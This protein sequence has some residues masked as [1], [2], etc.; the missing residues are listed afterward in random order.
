MERMQVDASNS[1]VERSWP[2]KQLFGG[3]VGVHTHSG[4][5][6]VDPSPSD[7]DTLAKRELAYFPYYSEIRIKGSL[8]RG[9]SLGGD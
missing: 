7:D 2:E 5:Y 6:T 3:W 8:A 4:F 9:S 1:I